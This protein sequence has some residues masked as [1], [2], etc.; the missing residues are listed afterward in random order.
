[1][2]RGFSDLLRGPAVLAGF[3]LSFLVSTPASA[4]G[5]MTLRGQV[6]ILERADESGPVRKA[7]DD[8]ASDLG[9]VF[10]IRA[11]IVTRPA[12]AGSNTIEIAAPTGGRPRK[13]LDHGQGRPR[14]PDRRRHARPDLCHL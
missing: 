6:T 12:D 11:R 3:G 8:L 9:K 7:A 10:G 14:R 13:L 1:M 4:Q 5:G 2:R